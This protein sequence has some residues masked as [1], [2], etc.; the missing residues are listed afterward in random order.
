VVFLKPLEWIY[1]FGMGLD[2]RM[3]SAEWLSCP[4]ISVG[5]LAMGGRGKTPLVIYLANSLSR[6]NVE[7]VVLTRGYGRTLTTPF[8][9][10]RDVP[11]F[12]AEQSGDEALEIFLRTNTAVL[13]GASRVKNFR[14][15]ERKYPGRPGLKRVVILDD[16]FQHWALHRDLDIVLVHR[17]DFSD[18]VLPLGPLRE[19]SSALSRAHWVFEEE[20]DF[21]R[22]IKFHGIQPVPGEKIGVL[23]TRAPSSRS[24]EAL[25]IQY[26]NCELVEM[27]LP[28]HASQSEMLRALE[29]FDGEKLILGWKE[30]VKVVDLA[31]LKN[32]QWDQLSVSLGARRFQVILAELEL[33]FLQAQTKQSFE[34]RLRKL[35]QDSVHRLDASK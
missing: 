34:E 29:K 30:A 18:S 3:T 12:S 20:V 21:R 15:F 14:D 32:G 28:D 33:E 23:T 24:T 8:F 10:T 26:P 17:S 35:V 22:N 9:L 6:M 31:A 25:K 5:N 19:D 2:R 27:H 7:V 4:T 1:R 16:G 13:V 11:Q